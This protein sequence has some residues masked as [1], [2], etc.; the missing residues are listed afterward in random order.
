MRYWGGGIQRNIGTD[1]VR[2]SYRVVGASGT[3]RGRE[4]ETISG[5]RVCVGVQRV[6]RVGLGGQVGGV[7]PD[8]FWYV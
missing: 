2:D 6:L 1:S 5:V 8:P 3:G 7:T 4:G